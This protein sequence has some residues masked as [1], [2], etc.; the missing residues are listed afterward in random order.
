[1]AANPSIQLGTD[2]NW[3]IKE[4]NLLAYKK[5]GDRFFNKEF[6]FTRGSVATYVDKDG[7][8]KTVTSDIPR[9]DFLNNPK[10]HLLLEPERRNLIPY[11]KDF[12]KWRIARATLEADAIT[13]PDGG[14]TYKLKESTDTNSHPLYF[15]TITVS[16][17]ASHTMSIFV[18]AAGRSIFRINLTNGGSA[19]YFDLSTEDVTSGTGNI[20][21]FGNGWY[22]CSTTFTTT[23]TNQGVYIEPVISGTTQSYTGDG[24]SGFYVYGAQLEAG[25]Y[26]TSYIP[27]QGSAVTRSVEK[28]SISNISQLLSSSG[29][30]YAEIK[31]GASTTNTSSSN[32]RFSLSEGG[33]ANNWV[34]FGIESGDNLRTYVRASSNTSTD[35]ITNG[36]FPSPG[37]Y[38]VAFRFDLNNTKVFVN[39]IQKYSDTSS[40]PPSTSTLS[41]YQTGGVGIAASNIEEIVEIKETKLYNTALTDAELIA[42]T[43]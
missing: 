17:S 42:L 4:D 35:A 31:L 38:K 3:A 28:N 40:T 41:S 6:D 39:G 1:M 25:N 14:L 22:R 26:A 16:A 8:I 9:I 23:G 7:L 10:G 27:T 5:D 33:S 20:E 34:F 24:V 36:V 43:S 21:N 32:I 2:G 15:Q 30:I 13:S 18:K 29:V 12:S 19:T 37:I 11:S